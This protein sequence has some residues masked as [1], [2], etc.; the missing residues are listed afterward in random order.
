[1]ST[2][3]RNLKLDSGGKSCLQ[4]RDAAN[5]ID[6]EVLGG[7]IFSCCGRG[8]SF[9]QHLNVDSSPFLENFPDAPLSGIFCGGE[10]GRGYSGMMGQESQEESLGHS[11]LHVYSTVYLVVSYPATPLEC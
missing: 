9:F 2:N 3:L 7:L 8:D 11:C 5:N 10:I 4:T 6:N 1:M